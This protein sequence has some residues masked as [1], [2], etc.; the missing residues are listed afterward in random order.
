[1]LLGGGPLRRK[2]NK[3]NIK[4]HP[5]R[6]LSLLCLNSQTAVFQAAAVVMTIGPQKLSKASPKMQKP[7]LLLLKCLTA[8][9]KKEQTAFKIKNHNTII[10]L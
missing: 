7:R 1:M 3:A 6:E 2:A 10:R 9:Y 4:I 5:N 8:T